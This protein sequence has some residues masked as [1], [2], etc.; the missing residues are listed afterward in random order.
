M[1]FVRCQD[2]CSVGHSGFRVGERVMTKPEGYGFEESWNNGGM[3][4]AICAMRA[5]FPKLLAI[6]RATKVY[7]DSDD[8]DRAE[9]IDALLA[10]LQGVKL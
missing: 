8:E 2:D 10:V 1:Q 6:A 9:E 7:F 5:A 4:L 3:P